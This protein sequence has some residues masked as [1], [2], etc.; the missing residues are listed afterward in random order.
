VHRRAVQ[1]GKR[2]GDLD[3][4]V[5]RIERSH[6][7]DEWTGEPA[8]RRAR[9]IGA[10]H[11]HVA[12]LLDVANGEPIGHQGMANENEQPITK[13]TRSSRQCAKMSVGSSMSLPS[14]QTRR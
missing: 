3:C 4:R 1:F 7:H 2:S 6:R 14:R 9:H 13:A 8:G 5:C 12:T 11:R 10:I